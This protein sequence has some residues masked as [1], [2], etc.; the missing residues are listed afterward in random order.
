MSDDKRVIIVGAGPAGLVT[1]LGLAKQ[2]IP[3]TIIDQDSSVNDSPRANTYLP[4]TIKVLD[5]L[6][7]LDDA[8]ATAVVGY[9]YQLRFAMT[10]NVGRLNHHAIEGLTPYA[11][12]LFFGQHILAEILVK[13][14]SKLPNVKIHWN[15]AFTAVEQHTD[16]VR[17]SVNTAAGPQI[18]EGAWLIGADGARSSV[19]HALGVEFDGF[20]WPECFMATN[21][22]Y[23]FEKHGYSYATMI[24]DQANWAVITK[25]DSNNLWRVAYQ[26]DSEVSE[27]TRV[28]RIP[29][30]YRRYIPEGQPYELARANSYRVHQRAA[31]GFRVGRVLLAGD[32]AHATNP[33]GGFGFTSGV[34]DADALIKYLPAF[35]NGEAAEDIL[36][37]YAYERRRVFLKVAN[38]TAIEMKRRLQETDPAVRAQDEKNFFALTAD[39]KQV[40]EALMAIFLMGGRPYQPDWKSTLLKQDQAISTAAPTP[41]AGAAATAKSR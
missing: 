35:M 7:V 18:L 11:Y 8:K 26:E 14:L 15:T 16:A 33:I 6:G 30:H 34:Q 9:E 2:G 10:G 23:D 17:V 13:H 38:P 1:A 28:A 31:A 5:E 37:W 21:V 19:R 39:R 24:A 29:E 3:V 22:Y 27:E 32:A 40:E 41:I 20:T 12:L 4:S 25:I 36:D